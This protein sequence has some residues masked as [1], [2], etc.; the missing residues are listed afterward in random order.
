MREL[1]ITYYEN[2]KILLVLENG[3]LVEKYEENKKQLIEGNIYVGKI[4][5]ILKGLQSAFINIGENKNAFIHLKDIL[6]KEENTNADNYNKEKIE[7]IVKVGDKVIVEVK[8][9]STSY[10][11]PR[12]STHITFAGVYIVLMPNAPF[13]TISKKIENNEERERLKKI[14][15]PMLPE[16]MG[17]IIRT[18]AENQEREVIEKDLKRTL[19]RWNKIINTPIDECPK[20]IY[21]KGGILRKLI[22]DLCGENLEKIVVEDEQIKNEVELILNELEIKNEVE[23]KKNIV[24]EYFLSKQLKDIENRKIYL[25]SGGFITIDKTEALTAIDVNSGKFTGKSNVDDTIFSINLEATKEIA[26]QI[27][28]R[29]I[30]GII[31]IDFIDMHSE[32]DKEKII[33]EMKKNIKLDR[34]K[35]QVEEF[36]KLNLLELTR[37]HI[38]K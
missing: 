38:N 8:R 20:I 28:L 3:I 11:G 35:V 37:K 31:I 16:N 7:N 15:E 30:G 12:V 18:S 26:K 36:T 32:N 1:L 9:E 22:I 27:R 25:N 17:A 14:I 6:P 5:N 24:K 10:K 2:K 13:L 19:D 4:Q 33:E 29:D 21:N 34:S 23:I